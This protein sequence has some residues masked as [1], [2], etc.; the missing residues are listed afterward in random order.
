M[1][2]LLREGRG[3]TRRPTTRRPATR[4]QVDAELVRLDRLAKLL[5]SQFSILGFRF[6]WDGIASL[7]PVVG[8]AAT[9]LPS[10]YLIWRA[11][12][13]GLPASVLRRMAMN[14][15]FDFVGGSVPV[16]GTV[17]DLFFKANL[18]NMALLRR[19]LSEIP[20]R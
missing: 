4:Q 2:S 6:G 5:D 14:T 12:E 16:A 10:A 3:M 18:K 17:F 13:L 11:R 19:H 15:A 7:V 1:A 20:E 8:D 9:M